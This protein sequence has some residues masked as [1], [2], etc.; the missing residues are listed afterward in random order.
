LVQVS[1]YSV[2]GEERFAA[3]WE[4]VEGSSWQAHH[5]LNSAQYQ[6]AFDQLLAE[7]YRLVQVSGYSVNGEERFAAIW[8]QRNGP[9]WQA[10]HGL[11][12]VQYQQAFDQLLREGYR[13]VQVSG[14]STEV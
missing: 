4:Q 12:S 6:Q 10:R 9:S 2:N 13:L 8:E 1:G 14:Y 5:G 11:S 7:G 3:I